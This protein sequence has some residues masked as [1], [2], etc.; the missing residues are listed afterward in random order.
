MEGGARMRQVKTMQCGGED[1]ILQPRPSPLLSLG[2]TLSYI[3]Q[4]NF[5]LLDVNLNK[6]LLD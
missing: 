2:V 1:L 3:T 5:F 6:T 4:L